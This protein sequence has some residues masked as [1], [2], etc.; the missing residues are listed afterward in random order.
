VVA[1]LE[2]F[3]RLAS[4]CGRNAHRGKAPPKYNY[5]V[6]VEEGE[7]PAPAPASA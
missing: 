6:K 1:I 3:R 7:V 2:E 4:V 5:I